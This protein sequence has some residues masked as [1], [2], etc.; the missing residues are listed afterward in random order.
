M[1]GQ[2]IHKF[3]AL[4]E[5]TN[6]L[7]KFNNMFKQYITGDQEV[8]VDIGNMMTG[9]LRE[10]YIGGIIQRLELCDQ[11]APS[12]K[13]EDAG[14]IL[15]W[16]IYLDGAKVKEFFKKKEAAKW[17]GVTSSSIN[18]AL[19][20]N[21]KCRG[22]NIKKVQIGVKNLT[23][24]KRRYQLERTE[25]RSILC[26]LLGEYI[27][28]KDNVSVSF[29]SARDVR[30]LVKTSHYKIKNAVNEDIEINGFKITYRT[31][32]PDE[33]RAVSKLK[34]QAKE[35]RLFNGKN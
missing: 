28:S 22:Y 1:I 6:T 12:P 11:V 10:V 2:L 16:D 24:A 7:H 5:N 4:P 19:D 25:D 29:T 3:D 31:L 27:A 33:K 20:K 26:Y 35:R 30:D 32:T 8:L 18:Q 21:C 15:R 17:I 14:K 13:R 34:K 23:E 9:G